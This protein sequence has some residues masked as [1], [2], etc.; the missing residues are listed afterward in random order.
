MVPSLPTEKALSVC[1]EQLEEIVRRSGGALGDAGEAQ[2]RSV[3]GILFSLSGMAAFAAGDLEGE[4]D[5]WT[6]LVCTIDRIAE[7]LGENAPSF[8]RE[9]RDDAARRKTEAEEDLVCREKGISERLFP[10]MN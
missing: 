5:C 3:M 10:K 7:R 1:E 9:F 2:L 6:L 4:R 8:I